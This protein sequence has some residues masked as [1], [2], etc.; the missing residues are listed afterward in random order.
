VEQLEVAN[1]VADAAIVK[2]DPA[3]RPDGLENKRIGLYWNYKPGGDVALERIEQV[4]GERYPSASFVHA[5]GTVGGTVK[6]LT[7][8]A[9]DE[10]ASQIDVVVGT[11]GD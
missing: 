11:T 8:K 7:P 2:I 6:H 9:A 4:L 1:P 5:Q 3:P 10:F